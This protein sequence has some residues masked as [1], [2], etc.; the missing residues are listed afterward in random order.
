MKRFRVKPLL[1]G[2]RSQSGS[3]GGIWVRPIPISEGV[4]YTSFAFDLCGERV[5]A[6][7][8]F[9]PPH[10]DEVLHPVAVPLQRAER[11]TRVELPHHQLAVRGHRHHRVALLRLVRETRWEMQ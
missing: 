7:G 1:R 2:I 10:E 3:V 6:R 8:V 5:V 11:G 9:S 4:G